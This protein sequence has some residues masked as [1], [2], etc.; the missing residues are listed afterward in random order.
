MK[1]SANTIFIILTA[2]IVAAAAYW[3]LILSNP[4]EQTL[5]V[6]VI[7]SP[8]EVEFQAL[9]TE[10]QPVSFVTTIFTDPEFKALQDLTVEIAPEPTNRP[11][12]FAPVSGVSAQP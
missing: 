1:P 12:P 3:Y 11:D 6:D 9:V 8:A 5:T 10:L 7:Q 4:T 2:I